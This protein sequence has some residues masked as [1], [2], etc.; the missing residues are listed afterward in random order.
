MRFG[1]SACTSTRSTQNGSVEASITDDGPGIS[2]DHLKCVFE[3]YFTTKEHG[4]GLGLPICSTI[5]RLP[6][7]QLTFSNS[8]AG[9]VT[10]VISLPSAVHLPT[11]S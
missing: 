7:G 5:D 1:Q 11:A 10:A 6:L 4:L 8:N 2:P 9:G 3:P